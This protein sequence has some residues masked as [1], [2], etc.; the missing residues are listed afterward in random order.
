MELASIAARVLKDAQSD[1]RVCPLTLGG[2]YLGSQE[3]VTVHPQPLYETVLSFVPE[4][5]QGRQ[6]YYG[7]GIDS[8]ALG[9]ERNFRERSFNNAVGFR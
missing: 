4:P 1:L 2:Y 6:S 9:Y 7:L 8:L 5:L 3:V